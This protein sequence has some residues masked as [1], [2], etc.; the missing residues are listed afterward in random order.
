[1]GSL[2]GVQKLKKEKINKSERNFT[3][4]FLAEIPMGNSSCEF[5]AQLRQQIRALGSSGCCPEHH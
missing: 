2:T 4:I 3:W 1:M 5:V